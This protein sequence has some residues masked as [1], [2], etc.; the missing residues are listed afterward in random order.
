VNVDVYAVEPTSPPNV[1]VVECKLWQD[2][3]TKNVARCRHA[4]LP[5]PGTPGGLAYFVGVALRGGAS[6]SPRPLRPCSCV[7]THA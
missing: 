3:I 1:I 6:S 2:A 4:A 5:N 7:L